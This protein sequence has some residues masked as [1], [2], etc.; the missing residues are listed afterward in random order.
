MKK[1]LPLFVLIFFT[2]TSFEHANPDAILG[3]WANGTNKGHIQL[4][5]QDGKYYGKIIWLKQPNDEA[6][7]P[8][9]DKNNPDEEA[10]SKRLLGLIMLR[11]FKYENGEWTDG[12]I[13]NPDDGKEYR[14]KMKLKDAKTLAVR[15]YIG[16]SLF[17]K[18]ENFTR[19]K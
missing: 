1:F 5:K 7:K 9:I 19:V 11:D 18:T 8:K 10:R 6:G 17:G 3:V 12:K 16:I 2:L 15:G 13:Y 4:Y 14:S